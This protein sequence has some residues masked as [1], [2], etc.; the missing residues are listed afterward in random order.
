MPQS[1]PTVT[2]TDPGPDKQYAEALAAG[3]FRI[4][5]C[6]DCHRHV[7]YPRNICPHC[8]R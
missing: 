3:Q 5:L 4:Q 7:F 6:Q 1:A 2:V 8:G